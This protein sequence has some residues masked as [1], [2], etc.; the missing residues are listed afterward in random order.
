MAPDPTNPAVSLAEPA[1]AIPRVKPRLRGISHLLALL[2]F[3]PLVLWLMS[4]ARGGPV[5]QGAAVYGASIVLMFATSSVYHCFHWAEPV[6][7]VLGRIDHSAIF[8]LIAGT[9][10]PFGLRIGTAGGQVAL[11]ALWTGSSASIW[12][13]ARRASASGCAPPSTWGWAG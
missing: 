13:C 9:F 12:S 11:A 1:A 3:V 7:A 5:A 2:T 8:L 10:T 6:R 4:V